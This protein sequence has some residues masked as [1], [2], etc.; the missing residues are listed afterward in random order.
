MID[1]VLKINNVS[2][3]YRLGELGT[4]TFSHDLK[5]WWCKLRGKED[6]Y[7]KIIICFIKSLNKIPRV[8]RS[9]RFIL[10]RKMFRSYIFCWIYQMVF[11]F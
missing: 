9:R 6:P 11:Q 7:L 2:K 1:T 10:T 8:S 3:Q 4:G 5:R